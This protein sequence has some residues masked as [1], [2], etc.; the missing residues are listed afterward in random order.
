MDALKF[1]QSSASGKDSVH[2]FYLMMIGLVYRTI[3]HECRLMKTLF[4]A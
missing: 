3:P 2:A 1:A 4:N